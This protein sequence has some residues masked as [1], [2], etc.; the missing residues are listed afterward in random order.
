M[1]ETMKAN[2]EAKAKC[3]LT[4]E[5]QSAVLG[6]CQMFLSVHPKKSEILDMETR[7]STTP[8]KYVNEVLETLGIQARFRDPPPPRDLA[9]LC[10]VDADTGEVL[11][12]KV[13]RDLEE[14]TRVRSGEAICA[15]LV[16]RH[17]RADRPSLLDDDYFDEERMVRVV[18]KDEAAR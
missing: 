10:V 6:L 4:D 1:T 3:V 16:R 15:F 9:S 2:E 13:S 12:G 11:D 7:R 8:L 18:S 17:W 5:Q 14:A